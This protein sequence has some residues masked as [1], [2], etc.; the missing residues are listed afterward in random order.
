MKTYL[1]TLVV[2]LS[3]TTIAYFINHIAEKNNP[4]GFTTELS[5]IIADVL[6]IISAILFFGGLLY[7]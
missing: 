7:I 2:I 6:G 4:N 1:I 5:S 3:L